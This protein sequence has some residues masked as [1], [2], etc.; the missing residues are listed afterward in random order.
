MPQQPPHR[1]DRC[2]QATA[3]LLDRDDGLVEA[4]P[5][6]VGHDQ[7]EPAGVGWKVALRALDLAI[8]LPDHVRDDPGR[9]A[10][11]GVQ[12]PECRVQSTVATQ[13]FI[14]HRDVCRVGDLVPQLARLDQRVLR[15]LQLVE[16]VSIPGRPAELRGRRGQAVMVSEKRL[17]GRRG[18]RSGR[19]PDP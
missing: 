14:E 4:A 9:L 8:G 17:E 2:R 11:S 13:P 10:E 6:D 12:L 15:L 3:R 18:D 19:Q 1:I 7:D 16:S 5:G